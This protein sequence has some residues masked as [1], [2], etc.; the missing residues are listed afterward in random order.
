MFEIIY[1]LIG[2]IICSSIV[3]FF[4]KK[5]RGHK[6][7][8]SVVI[9]VTFFGIICLLL[10]IWD[11][12]DYIAIKNKNFQTASGQCVV[13]EFETTGR[14]TI[15]E[16]HVEINGDFVVIGDFDDFSDVKQGTYHCTAKYI[17]KTRTL[18]SIKPTH[19]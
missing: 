9:T 17:E 7:F 14:T 13:T 18:F 6:D 4:V 1:A 11:T 3:I 2:L 12:E 10:I 19:N 5:K 16:L 8:Y 15:H